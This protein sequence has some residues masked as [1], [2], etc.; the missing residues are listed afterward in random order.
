MGA[1]G[2]E[3]SARVRDRVESARERQRARYAALGVLC[4]AHLPGPVVRRRDAAR[5]RRRGPLGPRGRRP[6]AHRPWVRPRVEGRPDDRRPRGR[7]PRGARRIWPR[8]S[9]TGPASTERRISPVRVDDVPRGWP[10][11]FGRGATR[12]RAALLVLS[13]LQGITPRRL[14]TRSRGPR[15]RRR[16]AS[17]RS[18]RV[19]P[20]AG[21]TAS[22]LPGSIPPRSRRR[23]RTAAPRFS[24]TAAPAIRQ[25]SRTSSTT[26]RPGSSCADGRSSRGSQRVAIVGSRSCSALGRE[27]AHDLGARLAGAGVHVVSGAAHGIDAASHRGALAAPGRT[28]AVLGAGHRRRLSAASAATCSIGSLATRHGRERVPARGAGGA[29][30]LPG[31]QPDRRRARPGLWSWWRAPARAARGSRSITRSTSAATSSRCPGR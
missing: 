22:T 13:S 3:S 18:G 8:P 14:R 21:S 5:R 31:T 28:V 27:V 11:G 7:R 12:E 10:P 23:S 16:H 4:N 26:R 20:A 15:A 25:S 24:P 19:A 9:P 1:D 2:G 17:P 29:A 30:P 6:R